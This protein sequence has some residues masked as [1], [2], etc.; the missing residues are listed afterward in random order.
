MTLQD[1]LSGR[2]RSGESLT[3]AVRDI[4]ASPQLGALL[5]NCCAPQ[6][7][8]SGLEHLRDICPPGVRMGGYANGFQTTTSEWLSGKEEAAFHTTS[9][10]DFEDGV[11]TP[12]AYARHTAEWVSKGAEIVGGCCGVGPRHIQQVARKCERVKD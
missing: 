1:D 5:L 2:L 11:I 3:D 6:S 4:D 10:K 8:T 12:S 9:E 7:V